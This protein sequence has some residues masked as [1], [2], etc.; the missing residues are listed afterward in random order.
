M[1]DLDLRAKHGETGEYII[2]DAQSSAVWR[3]VRWLV[4]ADAVQW[5]L[6]H[7]KSQLWKTGTT[8]N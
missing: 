3:V 7:L 5:L 1:L 2:L 4:L 6:I 8:E